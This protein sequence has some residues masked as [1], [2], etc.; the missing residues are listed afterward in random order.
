MTKKLLTDIEAAE[1]LG[2]SPGTLRNWRSHNRGPRYIRLGSR[3]IRYAFDDLD[4]H[5]DENAVATGAHVN[6]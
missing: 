1:Y 2:I 6:G 5:I 4:Q 3:A